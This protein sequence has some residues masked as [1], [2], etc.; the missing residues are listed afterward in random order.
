MSALGWPQELHPSEEGLCQVDCASCGLYCLHWAESLIRE[1][2]GEGPSV[3]DFDGKKRL[4]TL[5]SWLLA[6]V[7]KAATAKQRL[8]QQEAKAAKVAA[9]A[10]K[11]APPASKAAISS[12]PAGSTPS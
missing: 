7:S 10:A 3:A 9:K 5:Q 8:A 12:Q 11:A 1:H 4:Q 2:R 6:L